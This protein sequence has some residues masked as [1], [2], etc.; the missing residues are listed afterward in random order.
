MDNLLFNL[1]SQ[2]LIEYSMDF[3]RFLLY[4]LDK[5]LG[6]NKEIDQILNSY[7]QIQSFICKSIR[8]KWEDKSWV[9]NGMIAPKMRGHLAN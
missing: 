7:R 5:T 4:A 2:V 6:K 1:I 8:S 9:T 3:D